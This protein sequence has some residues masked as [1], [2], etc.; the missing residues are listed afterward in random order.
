MRAPSIADL[1]LTVA[2][3]A[4]A[5]LLAGAAVWP[6]LAEPAAASDVAAPVPETGATAIVQLPPLANFAAIVERPLFA[7][8]RRPNPTDKALA[9]AGA[10][11]RYRLIG[12]VAAGKDRHALLADPSGPRPIEIGEG[13]ALDGWTV[14][15]IEQDRVILSGPAGAAAL[16]FGAA[17][18]GK[19]AKP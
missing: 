13:A 4:A 10:G 9:A 7:L 6:W 19:P 15:S 14:D 8:S 2:L 3:T 12:I 1:R 18:N 16:G 17:V 5:A 11:L